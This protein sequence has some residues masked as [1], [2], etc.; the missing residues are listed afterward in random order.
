MCPIHQY[1]KGTTR[2]ATH[3]FPSSSSGG[4]PTPSA[5]LYFPRIPMY[6]PL[7][8]NSLYCSPSIHFVFSYLALH[9]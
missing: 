2:Q 4:V 9:I 5:W 3:A 6:D 8:P 7:C 1:C